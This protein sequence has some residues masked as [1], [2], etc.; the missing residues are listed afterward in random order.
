MPGGAPRAAVF[1]LRLS[2]RL[3]SAIRAVTAYALVIGSALSSYISL[4]CRPARCW[5]RANVMQIGKRPHESYTSQIVVL[6]S[7][8]KSFIS[9]RIHPSG[10]IIRYRF[11]SI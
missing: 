2:V 9:R 6:L 8:L 7:Y 5:I 3:R 4:Y 10:Q 1:P 11:I